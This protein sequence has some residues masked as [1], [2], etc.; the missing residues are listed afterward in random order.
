MYQSLRDHFDEWLKNHPN[1]NLSDTL[2][3]IDAVLQDPVTE[4]TLAFIPDSPFPARTFVKAVLA[5][6]ELGVVSVEAC[7]IS[8]H[9][10]S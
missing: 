5:I 8:A 9:P 4:A 6:A 7:R 2:Q 10:D 3:R 1:T